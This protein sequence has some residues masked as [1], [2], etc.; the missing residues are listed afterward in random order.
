MASEVASL[1][2]A[3]VE[4]GALDD[5]LAL[6][7]ASLEGST[8]ADRGQA[9]MAQSLVHSARGDFA[10]SLRLSVDAG[11]QFQQVGLPLALCD[12]L[13]QTAAVLRA[14]G[15]HASAI[16]TLEHA[17]QL[18]LGGG[19]RVRAAK[20]LRHIGVGSSL[21]G[22]HQHALSCLAEAEHTLREL[23]LH[24]EARHC[25]LSWLNARSRRLDSL[26]HPAEERAE[27]EALLPEWVALAD[28]TAAAGQNRL[29]VMAWG[30]HAITLQP[31]GRHAEAVQALLALIPRYREFGMRP[32][33]GLA[34]AELGR[35]HEALSQWNEARSHYHLALE[36]LRDSGV[37]D[38][39][40]ASLE[41]LSR[42]EEALG[43]PAAALAALKELRTI[44]KQRT[45]AA[46]RQAVVQRELRIEMARLTHQWARQ[47]LQDPLTGL[48]NRRALERWMD[49]HWP[50]V[51]LGE[52]LVLVLLDLDHFKRVN[53]HFGHDTGDEVLRQVAQQLQ[54]HT[55]P[56]DLAVRYGGE[57]FLLALAGCGREMAEARAGRLR[58]A[59]AAHPWSGV[60]PGLTVTTSI[61]VADASEV[62]DPG[63][64]FTL[65]DRRL[66]AAKYGG[67][68]RVVAA[69]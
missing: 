8:G 45:D 9:L 64:L 17:E 22:H 2:R 30:N 37:Q 6:A 21:L 32:N 44:E 24:D 11:E 39:L 55:G 52:P 67:R 4:R 3:L 54:S 33:E 47:A 60:A 53:D 65:A 16:G 1:V 36:I 61:G 13:V 38:D 68:D 23:Q 62:L 28:E 41:G 26:G 48:A 66:Y 50:R 43:E 63:A 46:A 59:V 57:E 40:M 31:C 51:E 69:G 12:A 19:D 14:A 35:C 10:R 7:T 56:G 20:V 58:Q 34:H 49:T 29:S 42:C 15:D 5:A 27:S 18:A 25:R